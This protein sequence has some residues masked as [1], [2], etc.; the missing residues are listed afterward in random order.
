MNIRIISPGK[1]KFET[2]VEYVTHQQ[3]HVGVGLDRTPL[4][5][6]IFILSWLFQN[7]W[8]FSYQVRALLSAQPSGNL[9]NG[10]DISIYSI[11]SRIQRQRS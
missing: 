3:E 10:W 7:L 8:M 4:D 6:S 5:R 9:D 1:K 11:P 2:I